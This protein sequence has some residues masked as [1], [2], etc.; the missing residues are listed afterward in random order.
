PEVRRVPHVLVEVHVRPAREE[1]DAERDP[2]LRLL[3][4]AHDHRSAACA[5]LAAAALR[6]ERKS[7]SW[8]TTAAPSPMA[9]PTRFTDPER[10]SP[11]A[12]MPSTPVSS[13]SDPTSAPVRMN[14]LSSSGTAHPAS[15]LAA[16]SAPVNRK[17]WPTACSSS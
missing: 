9:A 5:A 2:L 15:Q 14:P 10:T 4:F 7:C 13:G 8:A 12:K 17:Q 11:T 1:P 16:G 3:R 6:R